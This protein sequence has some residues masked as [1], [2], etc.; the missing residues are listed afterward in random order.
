M[1][2]IKCG[3]AAAAALLCQAAGAQ[4]VALTGSLGSKA[5]LMING[6]PR[7]VA[8]GSTVDGVRLLSLA[9]GQAVVEASGQRQTLQL[10]GSPVSVAGSG[11]NSTQ[12][13]LQAGA[14]GHFYSDGLINGRPVRFLVDTGATAVSMTV[15]DAER[16]GLDYKQGHPIKLSTANGVVNGYM[17]ALSSV[18]V[19]NVEVHNVQGVVAAREMPYVLLGNTFLTR[20]QMRREN[21]VMTLDKRF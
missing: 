10:G 3:L 21:D 14:G 16:I 5:L 13:V 17:V 9:G 12:I 19:G 20:F 1:W 15:H 2:F 18:K 7:T 11:R 6:T 4:S 8:V